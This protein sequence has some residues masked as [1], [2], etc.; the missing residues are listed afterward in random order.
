MDHFLFSKLKWMTRIA[1]NDFSYENLVGDQI[2][3]F[4]DFFYYFYN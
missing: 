3:I 4:L 2:L 1:K